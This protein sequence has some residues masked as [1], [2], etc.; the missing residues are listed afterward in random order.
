[1]ADYLPP[2]SEEQRA[3]VISNKSSS[4][5]SIMSPLVLMACGYRRFTDEILR[6]A[7]SAVDY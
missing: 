7:C 3:T 5:S 2:L 1:M 6:A 4:R